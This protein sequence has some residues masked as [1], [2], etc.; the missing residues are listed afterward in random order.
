MT[1]GIRH[2]GHAWLDWCE[3][4]PSTIWE[5]NPHLR[6]ERVQ[7]EGGIFVISRWVYRGRGINFLVTPL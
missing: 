4:E 1:I 2:A 5:F 7:Q 3:G 6:W